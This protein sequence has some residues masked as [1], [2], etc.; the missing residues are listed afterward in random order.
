MGRGEGRRRAL[1]VGASLARHGVGGAAASLRHRSWAPLAAALCRAFEDLGPAF[2][3][4][5]QFL[6]VRPDLVPLSAVAEL[7]RLQDRARPLPVDVLRPVLEG[8]LGAPVG[9]LFRRLDSEALASASVSQVHRAELPDGQSV[10]VKIQRPGAA[11]RLRADLLLAGRLL[12]AAA[13]LTA[14]GRRT[15]VAALWDEVREAA[16]AELD[17]RREAETAE[18]LARNFRRVPGIRVP[19]VHWGWTSRRV[20]TCEFVVGQKISDVAARREPAYQALAERGARA[21]MKQVLEDGLYHA[22]LHPANLLLTPEGDIAYLDFGIVGRLSPGERHA[23]LGALAGLLA[24]DP[25]LAL[26]HLAHLGVRVAPDRAEGLAREVAQVMDEAL[27][28]R[29]ADLSVA[30]LGRGLLAAVRRHRVEVPRRHALLIK[31]LLTVEGSA[32]LLHPEFSF[33]AAARSFL[34]ERARRE[35]TPSRL[36]EAAW[37]GAALLGVGA[38]L[39]AG[40]APPSPLAPGERP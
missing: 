26:R 12:G 3:K 37:R 11:D 30:R 25:P 7:E 21:F 17:F 28:P 18:A 19:R 40:P 39:G 34:V 2:V 27:A 14:A 36:A 9:R 10:A 16:E 1:A 20:L 15:D 8:E 24:R 4:L 29:L 38:L 5:G 35:L 31:A 13:R 33:E 6:S 22:D 32:R 23:V